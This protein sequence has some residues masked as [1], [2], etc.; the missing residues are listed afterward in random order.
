MYNNFVMKGSEELCKG[1]GD[2]LA[3]NVSEW[4]YIPGHVT[5]APLGEICQVEEGEGEGGHQ[6]Y[7]LTLPFRY[8]LFQFMEC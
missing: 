7:F 1:R 6:P 2:I 8:A 4:S 5:S 3:W